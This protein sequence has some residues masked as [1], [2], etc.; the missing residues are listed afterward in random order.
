[1]PEDENESLE[2]ELEGGESDEESEDE[3]KGS[4]DEE[5]GGGGAQQSVEIDGVKYTPDQAKELQTKAKGYD[6]LLPDYT[7]KS[8]RLSELEGGDK[9]KDKTSKPPETLEKAPY[10]D[11]NWQPKSYA[12]LGEALKLAEERGEKRAVAHLQ[13]MQNQASEVKQEVDDFVD[14]VKKSDADFDEQDFF[15]YAVKHKFPLNTVSDLEAVLSSYNDF[16]EAAA[17]GEERGR[18][19]KD[20]RADDKVNKPDGGDEK[21]PSFSDIRTGSGSIVDK[22]LE[23]LGRMKK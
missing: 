22:A 21:S 20:A 17:K 11:P 13:K 3:E 4:T 9:D 16:Q 19:G 1:M 12:E 6:A 10:E 7:K 5:K 15:K 2:D 23:G 18:K 8:Q 14:N